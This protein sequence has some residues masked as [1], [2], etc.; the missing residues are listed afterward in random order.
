MDITL[1]ISIL[2]VL[3]VSYLLVGLYASKSVSSNMDY[4]LAGKGLGIPSVTFTLVATQLGGGMLL[5]TSEKAYAV[6]YYGLLYT[7]GMTI[8]FLLLGFGFAA[9]LQ[10]LNVATTAELFET[11]YKS[12]QLRKVASLLSIA[13]MCGLLVG[14]IVGSK[15][16]LMGL[17]LYNQWIFSMLW[18]FIIIYTM[19]GGLAAVVLTDIAQVV[20]IFACFSALFIYCLLNNDVSFFAASTSTIQKLFTPEPMSIASITPV[21]IMPALFSLIEQDLAQRFFA[22]RSQRVATISALSASALILLFSMVPLYFGMELKLLGVLLPAGASPLIPAI[23]L[24]ISPIAAA[25][26]VCGVLAAITST[27]DSLLC[28]ISS[29]IAQDFDF[30]VFGLK[31][32]L[33][34]SQMITLITG[35]T[36]IIASYAISQDIIQILI[37]SY[38]LSVSCLFIPLVMCYFKPEVKTT[39]ARYSIIAGG[40]SMFIFY[41]YPIALPRELVSLACSYIGYVIG[42]R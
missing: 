39:A 7:I 25:F 11:K 30:S 9:K 13:T 4:F 10:S 5:G 40:L 14:Q 24:L 18:A 33:A 16:L 28:A 36:A 19:I 34:L 26:A 8:G 22:A 35:I 15:A 12:T 31:K 32:G 1:F 37:G 23:E 17:G 21:I 42:S 3:S 29:N 38:E 2:V 6:G 27:A 41:L 20:Y